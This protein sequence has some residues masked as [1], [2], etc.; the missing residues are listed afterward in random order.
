MVQLLLIFQN[1]GTDGYMSPEVAPL[2]G[3]DDNSGAYTYQADLW[4]L[5]VSVFYI[6]SKGKKPF[7][8]QRL[9]SLHQEINTDSRRNGEIMNIIQELSLIHI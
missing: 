8:V 4:S 2:L 1:L 3:V 6:A 9:S 7:M 5:S